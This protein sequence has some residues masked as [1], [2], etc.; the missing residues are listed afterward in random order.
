MCDR[1]ANWVL[2]FAPGAAAA[3]AGRRLSARR[4]LVFE[5][6]I[7][8]DK[9]PVGCGVFLVNLGELSQHPNFLSRRVQDGFGARGKASGGSRP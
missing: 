8:L 6:V 2:H 1:M 9:C 3:A 5:R 4:L 7:S